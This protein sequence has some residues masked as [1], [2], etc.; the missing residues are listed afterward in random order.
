MATRSILA[1][2]CC[3]KRRKQRLSNNG[4]LRLV[5]LHGERRTPDGAPEEQRIS[6]PRTRR[7][8]ALGAMAMQVDA[9]R[10][11]A[12]SC[13]SVQDPYSKHL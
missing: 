12:R 5:R 1:N 13:P 11:S 3:G 6:E 8:P 2:A 10:S 7:C 9:R 4:S